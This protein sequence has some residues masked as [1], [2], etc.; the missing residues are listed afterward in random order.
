M[1]SIKEQ[2]SQEILKTE[3]EI[4]EQTFK[5][6]SEE[7]H[8]NV[9]QIL[10]LVVLNLSSI[11]ITDTEKAAAKIEQATKLVEKAVGD[12][13]NLSKSLDSENISSLGLTAI[14]KFELELLEKTGL[15][16]TSFKAIGDEKRLDGNKELVIYRIIQESLNNIIKHAKANSI[17]INLCY[18]K[19]KLSVEITDNGIGF[20]TEA[21]YNKSIYQKGAGIKNIKK[22][23]ALI[24]L[25]V[26]IKS[27]PLQGTTVSMD[28]EI[29]D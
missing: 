3:L 25:L 22:R 4:K 11:E 29:P 18:F 15:Y 13:R 28:I 20:D 9:G 21:T 7:I 14:I 8:D 27:V 1:K 24:G 26:A 6:L 16:K 19:N 17:G 10:S 23:A 5:N 12:L 2:Y